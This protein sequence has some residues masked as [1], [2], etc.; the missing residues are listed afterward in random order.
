MSDNT[1]NHHSKSIGLELSFYQMV[2]TLIDDHEE[3]KMA[4]NEE[5]IKKLAIVSDKLDKMAQQLD[6]LARKHSQISKAF[7]KNRDGEPDYFGHYNAHDTWMTESDRRDDFIRR[8]GFEVMKWGLI[9]AAGWL[10]LSVWRSFLA[11]PK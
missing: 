10:V 11:G 1:N 4:H 5:T 6:D 9:G 2:K 8:L 3:K 7:H